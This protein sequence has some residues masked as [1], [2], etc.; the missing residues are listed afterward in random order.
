MITLNL[1]GFGLILSIAWW[2][3][4]YPKKQTYATNGV[5]SI[6]VEN[7][8]YSPAIVK[9][10]AGHPL[11][12]NFIRKDASPCAE[13]VIFPTLDIAET[14][15]LKKTKTINLKQLEPG[16]YPFHCQ[17]QMYKGELH[18]EGGVL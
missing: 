10:Q 13:S 16:T 5:L 15:P 8:I 9:A 18:V 1:I 4:F 2:F 12:L 3:W 11:Q 14:L 7:G 17:M 6:V